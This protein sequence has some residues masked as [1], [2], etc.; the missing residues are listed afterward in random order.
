[1]TL[2]ARLGLRGRSVRLRFTVLYMALFLASGVVLLTIT[3]GLSLRGRAASQPVG[4]GRQAAQQTIDGLRAQ[5]DQAAAQES[6]RLLTGAAVALLVMIVVSAV[7]GR[8]V[9]GRVLRPLRAI[10]TTTRRITADNLHERLA[11]SA[12]DDDVKDL[13]DT[14]DGLLERLESA[15]AAQRLFAANASHEL[16]T[17]LATMRAAVDVAVAKPTVPA[18]TVTLAD[19]VRTELDQADRLLDGLLMLARA[20]HGAPADPVTVSLTHLVSEALE[21]RSDGIGA[22]HLSVHTDLDDAALTVG[23][24]ALLARMVDNVVDNAITHNHD[25]GWISV[26][27]TVDG[28]TVALSVET[29]GTRIDD[30]QISLLAQPFHRLAAQRTGNDRGSGLGLSIVSAVASAHAGGIELHARQEGGLRV[31][32]TLPGV[33]A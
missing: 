30:E 25:G 26:A 5:L 31:T 33:P 1:M 15:F 17:P 27:V 11:V 22:A 18:A 7:L 13:A 8:G 21:A 28:R 12:P 23:S 6:Q 16:R 10:T 24:R 4:A 29:G 3:V 20:Q 14:I 2:S 19:R 32:I 9:A